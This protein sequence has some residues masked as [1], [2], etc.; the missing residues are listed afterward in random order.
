MGGCIFVPLASMKRL[1][2]LK[3]LIVI[4]YNTT[5]NN[6]ALHNLIKS[7]N[8]SG[9]TNQLHHNNTKVQHTFDNS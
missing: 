5:G 1:V 3:V 6:P 7:L 4:G 2:T 8:L 9:G